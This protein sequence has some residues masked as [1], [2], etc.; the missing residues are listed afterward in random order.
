MK[1]I[2][3][4]GRKAQA[5]RATLTAETGSHCPRSGWWIPVDESLGARYMAKGNI[6]PP[7]GGGITEW[8][9]AVNQGDPGQRPVPAP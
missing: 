4:V 5:F 8:R 6:M 2:Q 3:L 9:L 7:S 1:S